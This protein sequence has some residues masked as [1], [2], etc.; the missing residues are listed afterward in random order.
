[1]ARQ[2]VIE[3]AT[4]DL[5]R[6][7][8]TDF[9]NDGSFD[10]DNED[11]RFDIPSNAKIRRIVF[12][13]DISG[14]PEHSRW[15]S[16]LGW[17]KVSGE[18]IAL[19][20]EF[21]QLKK[22]TNRQDYKVMTELDVDFVNGNWWLD[23]QYEA[24]SAGGKIDVLIKL[25]ETTFSNP[26]MG[27]RDRDEFFPVHGFHALDLDGSAGQIQ[28]SFRAAAKRAVGLRNAKLRLRRRDDG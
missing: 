6:F 18:A 28:I 9:E 4:G 26:V 27:F 2:G 12:D 15:T 7:G 19:Y 8:S 21:L 1:M 24:W 13:T 23:Y 25:G 14:N 16:E 10:P 22:T 3:K 11:I 20:A 5:L 17:H